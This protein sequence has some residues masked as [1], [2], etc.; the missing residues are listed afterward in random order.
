MA[1]FPCGPR[2][3]KSSPPKSPRSD[4]PD[5]LKDLAFKELKYLAH[6]HPSLIHSEQLDKKTRVWL[7]AEIGSVKDVERAV[8]I[9]G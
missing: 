2:A 5:N 1:L 4:L 7:A 8:A 9:Y 6:K 3:R